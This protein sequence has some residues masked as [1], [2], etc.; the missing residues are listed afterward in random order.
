MGHTR[1]RLSVLPA[2]AGQGAE[3]NR[4]LWGEE[5]KGEN[6]RSLKFQFR[7]AAKALM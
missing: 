6:W 4:A 3:W 2:G 1:T 7:L 5:I